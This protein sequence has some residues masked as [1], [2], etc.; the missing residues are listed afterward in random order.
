M[1]AY[2]IYS[3]GVQYIGCMN[4]PINDII[5]EA[6]EGLLGTRHGIH[7]MCEVYGKED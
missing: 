2:G 5:A 1:Q 3:D 6:K 4:T 7:K